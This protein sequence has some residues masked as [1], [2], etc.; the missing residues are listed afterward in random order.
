MFNSFLNDYLRIFNSSFPLQTVKVKKGATN[1]KWITKGIKISCIKKRNLY[2]ACRHNTNEDAKQHYRLYSKILAQVIREAKTMY[3]NKKIKKSDNKY[4]ATWD[5][6]KEMTGNQHPKIEVQDIKVKNRHITDLQK[7][8][9]VFNDYFTFKEDKVTTCKTPKRLNKVKKGNCG[10]N[11]NGTRPSSSFT[12][13]NLS[14]QEISAIIKSIKT[15]NTCGYDGISTK[16]LKVSREYITSP[17]TY[18]CNKVI[19]TGIFPD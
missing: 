18:M 5:I 3:Y 8:I 11:L 7:V 10:L 9:D 12:L 2:L 14:T 4:K 1:N 19:L 6:I 16:L 17:L 13:R 15:K